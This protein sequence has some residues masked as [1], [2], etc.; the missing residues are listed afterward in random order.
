MTVIVTIDG[1]RV[2]AEEGSSILSAVNQ[3]GIYIPQ[4]CKDPGMDAIG[5]CRT[6]LVQIEGRPGFPAS[7]HTP[8]S[9]GLVVH[10][11]S[12]EVRRIRQGVLELTLG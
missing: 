2:E 12:L 1:Q 5:A 7:C 10:T 9:D 6:C 3:A 11:D 4:L 8:V